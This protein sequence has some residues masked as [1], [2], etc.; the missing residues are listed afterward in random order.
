V[1]V[2]LR[3]RVM[4]GRAYIAVIRSL[5]IVAQSTK[6][7][8]RAHVCVYAC[9]C[10]F[11]CACVFACAFICVCVC[12][13]ACYAKFYVYIAVI[14]SLLTLGHS[15]KLVECQKANCNTL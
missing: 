5:L 2:C 3:V 8:A 15:T 12:V 1:S 6:S 13:R 9:V 10:M 4:R 7:H 14:R 11:V